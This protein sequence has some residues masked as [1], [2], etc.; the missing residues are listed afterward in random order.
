[1]V[2]VVVATR[3]KGQGSERGKKESRAA[4]SWQ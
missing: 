1:V 2:V 4:G 3:I